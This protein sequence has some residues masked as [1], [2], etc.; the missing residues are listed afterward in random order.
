MFTAKAK[1]KND[2]PHARRPLLIMAALLIA[3][4]GVIIVAQL[5]LA[6]P[7]PTGT[8]YYVY[9]IDPTTE[10]FVKY[11]FQSDTSE[12]SSLPMIPMTSN[13]S[14]DGRWQAIWEEIEG[15]QTAALLLQDTATNE[16]MRGLGHFHNFVYA[17]VDWSPDD[18]WLVFSAYSRHLAWEERNEDDRE[19]WLV[20]ATT[21][22]TRR[23][24]DDDTYDGRP[25]FSPD[26]QSIAYTSMADGSLRLYIMSL[27]TGASRL[28]TPNQYAYD[29]AWSP[30]GEWLAFTT[31]TTTNTA[32]NNQRAPGERVPVSLWLI[33]A[34]GSDAQLF[35][36]NLGSV[37]W[38]LH[39]LE[40]F[41]LTPTP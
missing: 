12:H 33:R 27:A 29:I 4:F 6:P 31:D 8:L 26:G 10:A 24:T 36:A 19:L 16:V 7:D 40:R 17:P 41:D 13:V 9:S 20:N 15:E 11:D 18:Q 23:L 1:R 2:A 25:I 35:T 14:H 5:L 3:L 28:V 37:F 38:G 22:E 32:Y 39:W 30:D 34:D 21:G